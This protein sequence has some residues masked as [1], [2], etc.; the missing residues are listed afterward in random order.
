MDNSNEI[1]FCKLLLYHFIGQHI[2]ESLYYSKYCKCSKW[3]ALRKKNRAIQSSIRKYISKKNKCHNSIIFSHTMSII[4][5]TAT[6][7]VMNKSISINLLLFLESLIFNERNDRLWQKYF[8]AEYTNEIT[9]NKIN[10]KIHSK[11][12][13]FL[14]LT[15]FVYVKLC[16]RI[17]K[18]SVTSSSSH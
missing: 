10:L 12:F 5:F 17:I 16:I 18:N 3:S 1:K 13:Q 6:S 4:K 9:K 2:N 15:Q 14:T 7:K 8:P 11:I